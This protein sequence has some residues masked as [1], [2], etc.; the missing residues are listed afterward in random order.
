MPSK[1]VIRNLRGNSY[2]H[3]FNRGVNSRD[4]FLDR[5]DYETFLY[6][7]YIY[8]KPPLDIQA[9]YPSL[10]TRLKAKNLSG[11][12]NLVAYCLMHNHFH[13]LLKQKSATAMPKFIKQVVNGYITYF[14]KKHKRNGTIFHGRYRSARIESDYLLVQMIRYVHLNPSIAGLCESLRSYT[15]SSYANHNITNGIINRFS[16]AEEWEKFHLDT[17]SYDL[18][19]PKIKQLT[20]D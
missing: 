14:N 17:N 5:Q 20:I 19:I 3:V 9:K 12:I 7:L 10:P 4:I 15:W 1:Y 18:N 16:S 6:Y 8:T 13:L 11:D 2:Y